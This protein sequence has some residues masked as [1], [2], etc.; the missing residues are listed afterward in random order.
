MSDSQKSETPPEPEAPA[1]AAETAPPAAPAAPAADATPTAAAPP[2]AKPTV[3]VTSLIAAG[4][5]VV[6]V[7]AGG[8]GGF[9]IGT[10][11]PDARPGFSAASSDSTERPGI[12]DNFGPSL[13]DRGNFSDT[14]RPGLDERRDQF[15]EQMQDSD[16]D[17]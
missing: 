17:E 7:V 4:A 1:L 6:G 8:F 2:K 10:H 15:R 11:L 3:L 14:D 5:L 12:R 13:P 9:L 16:A